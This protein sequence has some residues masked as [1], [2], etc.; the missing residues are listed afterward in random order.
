MTFG[1]TPLEPL[2]R[3]AFEGTGMLA[4]SRQV[5]EPAGGAWA[6]SLRAALPIYRHNPTVR[7]R[8]E[9]RR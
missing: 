4:T 2:G 5:F 6:S 9:P 8:P 7:I 3:I 1:A